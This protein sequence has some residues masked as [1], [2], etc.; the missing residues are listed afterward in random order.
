MACQN[1][2]KLA[3]LALAYQKNLSPGILANSQYMVWCFLI[4][5]NSIWDSTVRT[6]YKALHDPA[7]SSE[8]RRNLFGIPVLEMDPNPGRT[9]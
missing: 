9:S 2:G 7:R 1:G 3:N 6:L 4:M 5:Q 8:S